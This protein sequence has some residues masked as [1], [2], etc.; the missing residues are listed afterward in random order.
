MTFVTIK[1]LQEIK[2]LEETY[3]VFN[4]ILYII[5]YII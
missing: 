3:I 4:T 1:A 2:S 5:A